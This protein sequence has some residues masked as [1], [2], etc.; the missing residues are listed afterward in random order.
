MRV[1]R[2]GESEENPCRCFSHI[3]FHLQAV[4]TL[5]VHVY[6][7]KSEGGFLKRKFIFYV[8]EPA[9]YS[10]SL[11]I[12]FP[13]PLKQ[14]RQVILLADLGCFMLAAWMWKCQAPAVVCCE[15]PTPPDR[16][17]GAFRGGL[18]RQKE[19]SGTDDV[20]RRWELPKTAQT[21]LAWVG[22]LVW[23]V[24]KE[25]AG[26]F[27]NWGRKVFPGEAR[28]GMGPGLVS[29]PREAQGCLVIQ[30]V[31]AFQLWSHTLAKQ[32]SKPAR[33]QWQLVPAVVGASFGGISS[34]AY[35]S[36]LSSLSVYGWRLWSFAFLHSV[37]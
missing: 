23:P 16:G 7:P 13:G 19:R 34:A 12:Y 29:A 25:R 5:A 24:R 32:A 21:L 11:G 28:R 37:S 4:P 17:D 8:M 15:L 1:T 14:F 6:E 27:S 18:S 22:W 20:A 30:Q 10:S 33:E 36:S 9:Y 3:S 2:A 26:R 31:A 35:S